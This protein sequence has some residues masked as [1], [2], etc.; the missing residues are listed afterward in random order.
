MANQYGPFVENAA[1]GY[2]SG[3][4]IIALN[5]SFA[6]SQGTVAVNLF[7]LPA[8]AIILDMRYNVDTV[9]NAGTANAVKIGVSGTTGRFGTIVPTV[10]GLSVAGGTAVPVVA[11]IGSAQ[12]TAAATIQALYSYTGGS[13]TTG[14]MWV[15][16]LIA[17]P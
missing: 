11:E 8:G 1:S 10:A 14:H 17:I 15:N 7:T 16:W 3:G 13:P 4:A 6:F 12:G 9:F 5:S 2:P